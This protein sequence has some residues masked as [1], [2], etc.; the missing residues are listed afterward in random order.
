MILRWPFRIWWTHFQ[1]WDYN[2]KKNAD[3]TYSW[4]FNR[5]DSD[6]YE[7]KFKC[8]IQQISSHWGRLLSQQDRYFLYYNGRSLHN[9]M[10]MIHISSFSFY[11]P[12]KSPRDAKFLHISCL[13]QRYTIVVSSL[14]LN[15]VLGNFCDWGSNF[16]SLGIHSS[17]FP[18]IKWI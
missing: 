15:N 8:M 13:T 18:P 4:K 3:S 6:V 7:N 1:D 16:N 12:R 11:K 5:Q 14:N 10:L 2:Y 17:V 9:S